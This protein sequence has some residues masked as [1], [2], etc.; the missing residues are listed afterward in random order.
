MEDNKPDFTE[1]HHDCPSCKAELI[2]D[3]EP[4]TAGVFICPACFDNIAVEPE[5]DYLEDG[6]EYHYYYLQRIPD[7]KYG[8][9]DGDPTYNARI[10]PRQTRHS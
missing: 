3:V 4:Y 6:G 9:Y 5:F 10:D 7:D 1:I 8:F 2:I